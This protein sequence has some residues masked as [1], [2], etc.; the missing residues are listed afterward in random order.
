MTNWY[1]DR[2]MTLRIKTQKC[3]IQINIDPVMSQLKL[4]CSDEI[5]KECSSEYS[6]LFLYNI[7]VKIQ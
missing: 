3:L 7:Y 6:M 5:I 2:S 4:Y 1:L